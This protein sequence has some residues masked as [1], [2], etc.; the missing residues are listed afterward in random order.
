MDHSA[1]TFALDKDDAGFLKGFSLT[2]VETWAECF[3]V[4]FPFAQMKQKA[5]VEFGDGKIRFVHDGITAEETL[6]RLGIYGASDGG[7]Y[8]TDI[9]PE[10]A[11]ALHDFF[12]RQGR[13]EGANIKFRPEMAWGKGFSLRAELPATA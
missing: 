8:E 3:C 10:D 4:T 13:Y 1:I 5:R 6:G 9:T 11:M 2:A 12:N 7:V